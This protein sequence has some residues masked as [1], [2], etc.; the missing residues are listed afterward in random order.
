[1]NCSDP[2]SLSWS[3]VRIRM[4]LAGDEGEDLERALYNGWEFELVGFVVDFETVDLVLLY[5]RCFLLDTSD[6]ITTRSRLVS[7]RVFMVNRTGGICFCKCL[8]IFIFSFLPQVLT[9]EIK[10]Y[11]ILRK[12]NHFAVHCFPV[13]HIAFLQ[14]CL[15][16]RLQTNY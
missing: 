2:R 7:W 16:C 15:V 5:F 9:S 4:I 8:A 3:S 6:M 11:S 1:M 10:N 13:R 12:E 14:L